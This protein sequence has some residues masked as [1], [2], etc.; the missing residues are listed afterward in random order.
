MMTMRYRTCFVVAA[1]IGGA[2]GCEPYI[3]PTAPP[4]PPPPPVEYSWVAHTFDKLE[5]RIYPD[6]PATSTRVGEIEVAF[7]SRVKILGQIEY[8]G[9]GPGR[10]D[11]ACFFQ[12]VRTDEAEFFFLLPGSDGFVRDPGQSGLQSRQGGEIPEV[13]PGHY[14][15]VAVH[16]LASMAYQP[17]ESRNARPNDVGIKQV[18]VETKRLE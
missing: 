12:L 1:L 4:P 11:E 15:V 7:P 2:A 16:A 13:P 10:N 5:S 9:S 6:E 8:Q 18:T 14:Y 17:V 3:P